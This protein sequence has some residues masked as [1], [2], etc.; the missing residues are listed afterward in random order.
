MSVS[1]MIRESI[2]I[3]WYIFCTE[4]NIFIN[5]PFELMFTNKLK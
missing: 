2:K 3:Y 4:F 5:A 1:I